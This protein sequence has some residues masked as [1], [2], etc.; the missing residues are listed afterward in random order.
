MPRERSLDELLLRA[1]GGDKDAFGAL[2]QRLSPGVAGYLR[3]HRC[4]DVEDVTSEVFLA[5]FR[6]IS[7]FEGDAAA[8]RAWL[9][10]LAHRRRVDAIRR[11]VRRPQVVDAGLDDDP[12]SE[13]S[14]EDSALA[15]TGGA[16]AL[17]H[18]LTEDQREVL[19]LRV[20]A[21][22]SLED[23]AVALG[24]SVGAV[25]SLQHRAL[26]ALRQLVDEDPAMGRTGDSGHGAYPPVAAGR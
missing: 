13:P 1:R 26:E 18:R 8:L 25:K 22:L 19:A 23:T 11:A 20:V 15:H 17:L 21:D 5:A 24:R 7:R 16:L 2:F 14:A 6:G 9:F 12:R 3:A 10:S 4:P